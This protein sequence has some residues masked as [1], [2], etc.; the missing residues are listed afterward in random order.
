MFWNVL[1]LFLKNVL[2]QVGSFYNPNYTHRVALFQF[3][4]KIKNKIYLSLSK[5]E[6]GVASFIKY[7]RYKIQIITKNRK[8]CTLAKL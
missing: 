8:F 3:K 1:K 4:K 7:F 6:R 2:K 5:Y